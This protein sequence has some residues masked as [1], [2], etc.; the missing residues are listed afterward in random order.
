MESNPSIE[1]NPGVGTGENSS[2]D[3]VSELLAR[4]WMTDHWSAMVSCARRYLTDSAEAED[5]ASAAF[6][7]AWERRDRLTDPAKTRAWLLSFTRFRA[8][9]AL[10]ARSRSVQH[11]SEEHLDTVELHE[12]MRA[13]DLRRSKVVTFLPM[14]PETQAE[15]VRM[16]LD[17]HSLTDIAAK[18]DLKQGTL[19][20]YKHR[21]IK[22]LRDVVKGG[23]VDAG[24]W[25]P[26]FLGRVSWSPP[27]SRLPLT[28]AP[29]PS[30][31]PAPT[32]PPPARPPTRATAPV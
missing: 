14:L 11:L 13:E 30:A 1:P 12:W 25:L 18:L 28:P 31:I 8:K 20:V 32:P 7:A 2:E 24:T 6:W 19:R 15:I 5:T 26:W 17:D 16:L 21:A 22:M 23:G 9:D 3:K 4:Q 27:N 29:L 10:R